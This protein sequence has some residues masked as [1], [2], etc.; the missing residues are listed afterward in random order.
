M[1]ERR[2]IPYN[3]PDADRLPTSAGHLQFKWT[4]PVGSVVF[5]CT[6]QGKG[7]SCHYTADK[8]GNRFIHEAID[9]FCEFVFTVFPWCDMIIAKIKRPR[10]VRVVREC[11]FE[12]LTQVKQAQVYVQRRAAYEV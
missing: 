9:E 4:S 10:V 1:I 5:S 8:E 2:F 3:G 12:F 6:K 11:G 7:M